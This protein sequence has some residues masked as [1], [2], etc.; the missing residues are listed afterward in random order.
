[1]KHMFR[2]LLGFLVLQAWLSTTVGAE[3][4]VDELLLAPPGQWQG[5]AVSPKGVHVAVLAMKGSR[6]VVFIDG[7][8]GPKIDQMLDLG[9]SPFLVEVGSKETKS[10]PVLFSEDGLHSVYYG[11]I[12][13]EYLVI[14]DGKEVARGNLATTALHFGKLSLSPNGKHVSYVE[15]TSTTGSRLV[16]DGKPGPWSSVHPQVVF[17]PDGESYAYVGAETGGK[18]TKWA[19]ING[20]QKKY[21]GERLQ[22]TATGRLLSVDSDGSTE[23]LILDNKPVMRAAKIG[24]IWTAANMVFASIIPKPFAPSILTLNGKPVPG[25][26]GATAEKVYFSPDGKRFAVHC[27]KPPSS[28]FIVLDGKKGQEYQSIDQ[29]SHAPAFTPD[30]AKL[31][32][33]AQSN[34]RFF[35]V[36]DD[37][38]SD[39]YQVIPEPVIGAGGKRVGFIAGRQIVLDGKVVEQRRDAST[40]ATAITHLAFSPNGGSYAYLIG[41]VLYLDGAEQ[42]G[43]KP[44]PFRRSLSAN[45]EFKYLFTPDSKHLLLTVL[46]PTT[47]TQAYWLDGKIVATPPSDG[48]FLAHPMFSPDSQHVV[49]TQS[50]T[51]ATLVFDGRPALPFSGLGPI[52]LLAGN[53]EWSSDNIL[54]FIARDGEAVKRF[55][56]TPSS[57]TNISL[58]LKETK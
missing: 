54:T 44:F 55:Q 2:N 48:S 29:H 4:K 18:R 15:W 17:S 19:V 1:M 34:A 9:G 25:T 27:R 52:E 3:V 42:V 8:E 36:V 35:I 26:E 38:E 58:L 24:T 23:T 30:S 51:N 33:T 31:V 21:F 22:F 53:W 56:L 13:D 57:D 28:Q 10:I 32:Y 37:V 50:H 5:I 47:R 43:I 7:V 40:L 45:E 46:S 6:S 14:H 20:Q 41:D 39:G 11:K 49:W 12:G 16:V